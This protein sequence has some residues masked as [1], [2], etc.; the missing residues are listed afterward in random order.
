M[1][2][3]E[4]VD[5]I[6]Q[7]E[8][9]GEN[10]CEPCTVLNVAI[11]M[12][13]G[14]ALARK[15]RVAGYLLFA[16][17]LG[18]IYLRGYLVPGTPTLTKQYLPPEVLRWFGKEPEPEI[19]SGL[20]GD[21]GEST[22]EPS[23]PAGASAEAASTDEPSDDP[24][25]EAPVE[26][27]DPHD[28][29]LEGG[30]LEPCEDYDDLCLVEE[31][32]AEWN[33]EMAALAGTNL[34]ADEAKEVLGVGADADRVEIQEYEEARALLVDSRRVGQWP[35]KEALLA[36]VSAA[37]VLS[38]W[39][40][41]WDRFPPAEKGRVLNGL[42]LFIEECPGGDG[43]VSMNHETV[44]SCCSSHDVV[45]VSCDET[46]ARLFEKRVIDI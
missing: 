38:D 45:T 23:D 39:S 13:L 15:S 6:R 36:D 20:G 18:L 22:D 42:R 24:T 1:M 17:S 10:R 29:L 37:R 5:T 27:V 35:S 12:L 3:V 33:D 41:R 28:F 43:P 25:D 31:F 46:G 32:R 44:E 34:T 26:N 21:V 19:R 7:P 9:T 16:A 40:E 4:I 2:D 14:S 11:A 8:Y 30:V